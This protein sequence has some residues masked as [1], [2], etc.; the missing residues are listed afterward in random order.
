MDMQRPVFYA[1]RYSR[2]FLETPIPEFVV[3]AS[4][5]WRP[6]RAILRVMDQLVS[7]ALLPRLASTKTLASESARW[8]LYV[9][10]H[11]LSMPPLLL[12]QHLIYKAFKRQFSS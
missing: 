12:T 7:Q 6:P 9:R 3:S 11:W 10:S 5:A 2:S 8:L 4:Q 1:L